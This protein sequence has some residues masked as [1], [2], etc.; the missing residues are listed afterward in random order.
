MYFLFKAPITNYSLPITTLKHWF[1]KEVVKHKRAK[2]AE[3]IRDLAI[4]QNP[5]K[6]F[7]FPTLE[8]VGIG[9]GYTDDEDDEMEDVD[10]TKNARPLHRT[11][12]NISSDL[13]ASVSITGTPK[14]TSISAQGSLK[15]TN[16]EDSIKNK[17]DPIDSNGF[18]NTAP[19]KEIHV[20]MS[21]Q[22]SK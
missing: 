21:S 14:A 4:K 19:L 2:I 7:Q 11:L 13:A 15:T 1:P 20:A 18:R 9:S 8:F 6:K 5:E 12:P 3:I 22:K 17:S 10:C 16:I